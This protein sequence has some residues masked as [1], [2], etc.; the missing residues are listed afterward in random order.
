MVRV[1]WRCCLYGGII[2]ERL[3][4]NNRGL[5][6]LSVSNLLLDSPSRRNAFLVVIRMRCDSS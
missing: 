6:A 3:R 2:N 4:R 5:V 1:L